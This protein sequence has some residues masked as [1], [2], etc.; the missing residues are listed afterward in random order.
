[1]RGELVYGRNA[2]LEALRGPRVGFALLLADGIRADKRIAELVAL[3]NRRGIAERVVPRDAL[4][5]A[6]DGAN[7][8]GVALDAAPFE[9]ADIDLSPP[10]SEL[11]TLALDHVQDP[12]NLGTLLRT[13]DAC[14][15]HQVLIPTD[16]AV[17]VTPAVVNASAGAVEHLRVA[18]VTNLA[19]TLDDLKAAGWWVIGLEAHEQ[20]T[21]LF[22]TTLPRPAVLV[23]GSEG[24]GIGRNVLRRCDLLVNLPMRGQVSSLNAATAASVALYHLMVT[25]ADIVPTKVE[26]MADPV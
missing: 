6:L 14:G 9:Y 2:A 23:V 20:S 17:I 15:V 7:H 16:R 5:R 18:L 3:A 11:V 1:M 21:D 12:R 22:T 8:Q 24:E 4:D 19:R 25:G 13:A 10:A 26:T